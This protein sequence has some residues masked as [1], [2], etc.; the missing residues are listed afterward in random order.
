[1]LPFWLKITLVIL[2]GNALGIWFATEDARSLDKQYL[3]E[4]MRVEMNRATRLLSGLV[5]ESVVTG[6]MRKTDATI[7]Q[8]V[9]SWS[10]VTYVHIVDDDG[11]LVTEWQKKPIQFGE[12]ILKFEQPVLYG[13][14]KFGSISL[15]AD[16]NTFYTA[17]AEHIDKTRRRTAFILLA[18][19]LFIVFVVNYASHREIE[20]SKNQVD[21]GT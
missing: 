6:D 14:E 12:G 9:S 15:Y 18:I 2:L 10:E 17:M 11:M 7:R 3:V 8:Y 13:N 1:M 21:A 19:T 4:D 5:A 16:L 20:L